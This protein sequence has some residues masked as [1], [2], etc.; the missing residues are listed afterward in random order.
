MQ[1]IEC[2]EGKVA[3]HNGYLKGLPCLTVTKNGTGIVGGEVKVPGD[4]APVKPEDELLT[5]TFTS[6]DSVTV[7]IDKLLKIRGQIA[8]L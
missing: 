4:I 3:V 8:E 2:G 6:E 5:V 1:R 7:W